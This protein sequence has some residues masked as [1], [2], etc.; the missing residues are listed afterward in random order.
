MACSRRLL[1]QLGRAASRRAPPLINQRRAF[2]FQGLFQETQALDGTK[3][4]QSKALPVAAFVAALA[5]GAGVGFAN[6]NGNGNEQQHDGT[7]DAAGKSS[8]VIV[9]IHLLF[10]QLMKLTTSFFQFTINWRAH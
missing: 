7:G 5:A 4:K 8:L 2:G 6:G 9:A 1:R 10:S 3:V